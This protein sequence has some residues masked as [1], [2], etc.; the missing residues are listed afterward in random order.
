[1]NSKECRGNKEEGNLKRIVPCFEKPLNQ[2]NKNSW[3]KDAWQK[4]DEQFSS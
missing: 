1:L 4:K 2:G 3:V